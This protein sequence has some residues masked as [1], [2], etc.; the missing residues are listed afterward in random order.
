M[1]APAQ[2]AR[3]GLP[4]HRDTIALVQRPAPVDALIDEFCERANLGLG[5]ILA[6]EILRGGQDTGDEQSS[7]DGR[8]LAVPGAVAGIHVQE[9]VEETAMPGRVAFRAL[10]GVGE[11]CSVLKHRVRQL[12]RG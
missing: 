2:K 6:V 4:A 5:L 12:P 8:K 3:R 9:V 10:L 7:I 11:K 1:V